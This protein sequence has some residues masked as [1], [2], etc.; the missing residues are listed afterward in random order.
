MFRSDPNN[1]THD[2][3]IIKVPLHNPKGAVS[4]GEKLIN[5]TFDYKRLMVGSWWCFTRSA[6]VPFH[7]ITTAEHSRPRLWNNFRSAVNQFNVNL[8]F[9]IY[10]F[11]IRFVSFRGRD[12]FLLSQHVFI[13]NRIKSHN[14]MSHG[15]GR[16]E[17]AQRI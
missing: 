5:D 17:R 11:V 14:F 4:E 2:M 3:I 6:V 10:S 1:K 9:L 8:W 15:E 7:S 16:E 12:I 13:G